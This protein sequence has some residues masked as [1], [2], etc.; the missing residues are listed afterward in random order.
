M[1]T[2][3]WTVVVG[4]GLLIVVALF[5]PG[6]S[7]KP[8]FVSGKY[9]AY[10]SWAHVDDL[11]KIVLK[12][13]DGR[14]LVGTASAGELLRGA[15]GVD[16]KNGSVTLKSTSPAIVVDYTREGYLDGEYI[17]VRYEVTRIAELP[18]P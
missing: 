6:C 15:D 1:N 4:L 9:S 8:D 14:K 17:K 5:S 10:T 7:R 16:L 18:S 11:G 13:Y 12:V 3:K 2:N